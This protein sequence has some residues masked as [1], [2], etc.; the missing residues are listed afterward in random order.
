MAAPS[1]ST[2]GAAAKS[3]LEDDLKCSAC[4]NHGGEFSN[5]QRNKAI[6][7]EPARC[8]QCVAS[9]TP[10]KEP[11]PET[12]ESGEEATPE[13][14][15]DKP[16][17]KETK[18]RLYFSDGGSI[19]DTSSSSS[20]SSS[21]SRE[22]EH[23]DDEEQQDVSLNALKE[24]ILGRKL[25]THEDV[26]SLD[27]KEE[28][29]LKLPA[30]MNAAN[31]RKELSCPICHE[32][33]FQ[34][35]SLHCGHSFCGE[36]LK[37]WLQHST[38]PDE[39]GTCPTC[40]KNLVCS[41][42]SL[43][44][45]TAL[46]AAVTALYGEELQKRMEAEKQAKIKATRGEN[47]GA[48]ARGY[49][50]LN[51]IEEEPWEKLNSAGD[52]HLLARRSVVLDEQDERMQLALAVQGTSPP[53][54]DD[55]S[56]ILRVT[57]CLVTMEEDEAADGGF[58]LCLSDVDDE[59]LVCGDER[60][61]TPVDV[62][63]QLPEEGSD[64]GQNVP[65]ARRLMGHD[66][67]ASFEIDLE[68]LQKATVISFRHEGTGAEYEIKLS[69]ERRLE[70]SFESASAPKVETR[71]IRAQDMIM[72]D[73]E[74]ADNE[75]DHLDE[76][77]D[78]GFLVMNEEEELSASDSEES[79]DEED[80]CC[81]CEKHGELIICDGGDHLEGCGKSFHIRCI[82]RDEVPPGDWICGNCAS[83]I[84]L[85]VGI[86]GHEFPSEEDNAADTA[87]KDCHRQSSKRVL[88]DSS[89]DESEEA[90]EVLAPAGKSKT[91]ANK[92]SRILE[93]DSDEA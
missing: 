19:S 6:M 4:G 87:N 50:V 58:P 71:P 33:F 15:H 61:H 72:M 86:E 55:G 74:D 81:V 83:T 20:S 7:G 52:G 69:T 49:E 79:N 73:A 18:E 36:C 32:P 43:G 89:G 57:L 62:T 12:K 54:L 75:S 34:P 17:K 53:R 47:G 25:I 70:G 8:K 16:E 77:E 13:E 93:S 68:P 3:K 67:A 29:G 63:T 88:E 41:G 27:A 30:I 1:L 38:Q 64:A 59:F 42:D 21:K 26:S 48:H 5:R 65:L 9:D 82:E 85:E 45:N 10:V 2:S 37:W 24:Q 35:L 56:G 76:Y 40:R 28:E 90:L 44:V 39:H 80:V 22:N 46:R 66:G 31:L 91:N 60:F 23:K 78:D 14:E 92:R 11:A 84:D 51:K